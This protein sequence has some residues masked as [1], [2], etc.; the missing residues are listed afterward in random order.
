MTDRQLL[1][2]LAALEPTAYTGEAFR[3]AAPPYDPLSGAG[4]RSV[5]GRWNP[6]NSFET[7]YVAGERRTAAAEFLRLGA[8]AGVDPAG[9]L[10]RRLH[11]LNLRLSGLVDL[12]SGDALARVGLTPALVATDDPTA[13]RRVGAMAHQLGREGIVAASATGSGTVLALFAGKLA[14]SSELTVTS[15]EDWTELADVH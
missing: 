1:E 12:R 7:L 6:P 2:A 3:H 13:C 9:F 5:G 11:V 15:S 4:A 8:K 14:A 10:P